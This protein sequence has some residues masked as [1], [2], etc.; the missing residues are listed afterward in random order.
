[1]EKRD[2]PTSFQKH[3]NLSSCPSLFTAL[4]VLPFGKP[5]EVIIDAKFL[6]PSS[7]AEKSG[8]SSSCFLLVFDME[9]DG[10]RGVYLFKFYKNKNKNILEQ[11]TIKKHECWG[12]KYCTVQKIQLKQWTP[13][14][15]CQ[16]KNCDASTWHFN[17]LHAIIFNSKAFFI[18]FLLLLVF[19]G[20]LSQLDWI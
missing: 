5:I 18:I 17:F 11:T 3:T 16:I 7:K 8:S 13:S 9:G 6:L 15:T 10:G 4:A 12:I 2:Y 14:E 19:Y 20:H 1:M